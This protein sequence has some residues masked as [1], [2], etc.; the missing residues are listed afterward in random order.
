MR[1]CVICNEEKELEKFRKRQIWFSHT[2]KSCYA[3]Q[4]RTGKEN[5]GWFKKGHI[6]WIKGKKNQKG[7]SQ[8]NKIKKE[9]KPLSE[10]PLGLKRNL[11][12]KQVKTR[13]NFKCVECKSENNLNAHHII[14]W[15]DDKSK[16]F[17][18]ENGKT[19]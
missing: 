10:H 18:I 1:K 8:K 4:Y 5:T 7:K 17:E 12:A 14:P 6:P 9:I 16:R 19:L 13:D 15:K 3:S 11:W 2:C